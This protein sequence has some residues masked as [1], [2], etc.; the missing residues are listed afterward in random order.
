MTE[1][2]SDQ[3]KTR[4]LAPHQELE[5]AL[6]TR[7]R[8]MRGTDNYIDLLQV[9]YRYFGALEDRITLFIGSAELPDHLQRRKSESLAND[10]RALG[11]VLPEKASLSEIPV[12]EDHLQAFGA[13]YVMEGSTLG[14]IIISKM[15][16][17]Q[18]GMG[19][20]GLSFFQ[21]Y[22]EH[23]PTMWATFKLTLNRQAG[24]EADAERIIAAAAETFTKFKRLL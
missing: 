18:L 13:L 4:T 5:K 3:L 19:D 21:S 17:K 24:N 11:G 9:F 12:I 1:L 10:I 22:G 2:L 20:Q 6:I 7:M 14:G 23:L 16:A 8:A 15:V